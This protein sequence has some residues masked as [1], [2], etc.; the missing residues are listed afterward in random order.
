MSNKRYDLVVI[1]SGVGLTILSQAVSFGMKCALVE[2][3]KM[4]GTCLTRGC[5]PSK[6]L[7]HV[8]DLIMEAKHAKK[9][10]LEMEIKDIDWQKI[11][12]R[13]WEQIDE[14]KDI[15]RGLDNSPIDVY[16][17]VGEF[18]GKYEMRVLLSDGSGYTETFTAERFVIASGTRSFIPPIQGL[19][20]VGYVTNETFFGEK[21]PK[22]PWKRLVILGGG[23]VA[24]EFAHLFSALGTAVTIVEM[25]PHLVMTEEPEISEKLELNFRERMNLLLGYKAIGAKKDGKQKVLIVENVANGKKKEIKAEE[26][27]VAAG[28]KSNA[29]LLKVEKTGIKTDKRGWIITNDYLETNVKNIWCIGDANGKFQ[30]RHKANHE[31]EILVSNIFGHKEKADYS[32]VPWAIFTYPQIAHVGMTE[33]EAIEQGYEI[34]VAKKYYSSVAKGFAM[35]FNK[36]DVEDG[37]VKII[38]DKSRKIL[39]AHIIG[40]QASVLIHTFVYLMNAGYTCVLPEK[41][42]GKLKIVSS[43]TCP[44]GGSVMPLYKSMTIHPSLAE[45]VGWAIGNLRPVNIKMPPGHEHHH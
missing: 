5:I 37:F 41:E 42:T 30:F 16:K 19:E 11:S 9:I 43:K 15:E 28:R 13:M 44:E 4:G 21:F 22:K 3:G 20:D 17:G 2:K 33:K 38:V 8:A 24:A 1:G 40:P 23:V 29:D 26:I 18:T 31:A 45:V 25:R 14:S 36:D 32:A 39:G 10:G 34:Y 35:G 7:I 12:R 6:V 27:F